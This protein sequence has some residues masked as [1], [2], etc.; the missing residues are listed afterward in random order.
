MITLS[1]SSS[2][3]EVCLSRQPLEDFGEDNIEKLIEGINNEDMRRVS[4]TDIAGS[5]A[6]I[7]AFNNLEPDKRELVGFARQ[8]KRDVLA[9]SVGKLCVV[10]VGSVWVDPDYRGQGIG[11][12]L[13]DRSTEIMR[14]V[15]F[16]PI[17]VCNQHSRNNFEK[18]GYVPI[19]TMPSTT[20]G[21]QR[22]V[23]MFEPPIDWY[24]R[25][26]WQSGVR[27]EVLDGTSS[28]P[29]FKTMVLDR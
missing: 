17:A 15:G 21:N 2:A 22:I 18:A 23:E 28:L 27:Q 10:E 24:V 11:Q 25:E 5:Y 14:I 1:E 19:G 20:E 16:I 8:V 4:V 12:T 26:R 29:R 3:L 9:T 13:I 6:A 7:A